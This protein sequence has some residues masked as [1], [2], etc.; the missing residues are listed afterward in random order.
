MK[1]HKN[2]A[3]AAITALLIALAGGTV[4]IVT[5]DSGEPPTQE[6]KIPVTVPATGPGDQVITVEADKDNNLD[7]SEQVEAADAGIDL[8]E[9]TRDETPPGV[10]PAQIQAGEALTEKLAKKE[11]TKPEPPAGSQTYSCKKRPVV[12]QSPLTERRVG[13]A[14]HFTVSA[15]GSMNAIFG[16]FNRPSF[17]ASS[18]YGYELF[19]NKCEQWVPDNRKA[20]AQLAANSAYISIEIVTKDR[21]RAEWLATPA[22]KTGKLASLVR[23]KL[24]QI[25]APIRLVDPKGCVWLAGVTDHNRLECGNNHWDVGNN[26]PWPEFLAQVKSGATPNPLTAEQKKNCSLLNFHRAKAHA[27]GKWYPSRLKRANELKALLPTG[28]CPS[29][30]AKA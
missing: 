21:S 6:V 12:N 1:N 20:W 4:A 18:N 7:K 11:L 15:P 30:Y 8:H 3:T 24:R 17:G 22:F 2:T 10:T 26:F 5:I 25:G 29:K 9:D 13:V 19:S 16:L 27:A 23:D 14:L 28:R